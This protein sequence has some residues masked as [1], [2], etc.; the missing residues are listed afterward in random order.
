MCRERERE[1][2]ERHVPCAR[3]AIE[4]ERLLKRFGVEKK[5]RREKERSE[6]DDGG[7]SSGKARGVGTLTMRNG[8]PYSSNARDMM[9]RP[10]DFETRKKAHKNCDETLKNE[11]KNGQKKTLVRFILYTTT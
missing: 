11:K 4:R 5:R 9:K 10:K 6:D 2:D 1:R 8:R 7:G 3:F